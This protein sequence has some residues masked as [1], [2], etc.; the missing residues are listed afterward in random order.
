M[1][2]PLFDVW[3]IGGPSHGRMR[4]AAKRTRCGGGT[5]V[6]A[7]AF[8]ASTLCGARGGDGVVRASNHLYDPTVIDEPCQ[9]CARRWAALYAPQIEGWTKTCVSCNDE[10]AVTQF[11]TD[12]RTK[13]GLTKVCFEC[14]AAAAAAVREAERF[15]DFAA[16][17]DRRQARSTQRALSNVAAMQS[18]Q[19][20]SLAPTFR[21]A[22]NHTLVPVV[23][24]VFST[25]SGIDYDEE[26]WSCAC[27]V[28]AIVER[29]PDTDL[30]MIHAVVDALATISAAPQPRPLHISHSTHTVA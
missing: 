21:C 14:K 16:Q 10:K 20:A 1:N 25:F 29:D 18:F 9:T 24:S 27:G 22:E 3:V 17:N 19:D 28:R 15:L 5:G 23:T 2:E 13:D 7:D 30:A 11:H 26:A 4:H 12:A 8:T 6:F